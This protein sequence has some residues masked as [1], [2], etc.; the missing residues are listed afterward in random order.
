VTEISTEASRQPTVKFKTI[1]LLSLATRKRV[2]PFERGDRPRDHIYASQLGSCA[3]A[4]WF[5]WKFPNERPDDNFTETRGA[6]GHAV[7]GLV[8]E[9]LNGLIAAQEV[10]YYDETNHISGRADYIIRMSHDGPMIPVELKTTLAYD[11]FLDSPMA[12]HLLQLRYYLTQI[13]E[14]PYGILIYYNL[15]GWG[16]KMGEWTALEIPRDDES[17]TKRAAYLW[18][19]VHAESPPTCEHEGEK[20]PCFD[21]SHSAET[22]LRQGLTPKEKEK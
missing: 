18:E 15:S 1:P 20:E 22:A 17:V 14:A 2:K 5:S 10:S 3:R 6:L 21:C 19:L 4:V 16:G 11:R 12:S 13:P 7:E 8:A 9:Q